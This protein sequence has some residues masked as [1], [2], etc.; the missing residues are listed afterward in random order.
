MQN[1]NEVS[2]FCTERPRKNF[3]LANVVPS[4][5]AVAEMKFRRGKGLPVVGNGGEGRKD[6][7]RSIKGKIQG[8][9]WSERITMTVPT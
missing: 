7:P 3:E 6:H 4:M 1:L 9:G 5:V 2:R 8:R